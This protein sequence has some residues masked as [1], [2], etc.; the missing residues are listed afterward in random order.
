LRSHGLQL[1]WFPCKRPARKVA[2]A[3]SHAT[4][5]QRVSNVHL[6]CSAAHAGLTQLLRLIRNIDDTFT[7]A[8]RYPLLIFHDD[9]MTQS[10]M[11]ELQA[12]TSRPL[13]FALVH[14]Q[15]GYD[16]SPHCRHLSAGLSGAI[17]PTDWKLDLGL[18]CQVLSNRLSSNPPCVTRTSRSTTATCNAT[19]PHIPGASLAGDAGV[20]GVS[21][22]VGAVG[23]AGT[24]DRCRFFAIQ[25]FHQVRDLCTHTL[26]GGHTRTLT[27]T[28][29]PGAQ[30]HSSIA[31]DNPSY[32]FRKSA[33]SR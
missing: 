23:D 18:Q 9:E 30:T 21:V 27:P 12:T 3:V 4:G 22:E 5:G 25:L 16:A 13:E 6:L 32:L 15:G 28:R 17:F 8:P 29:P 7:H 14:F 20:G 24:R 1:S 33:T 10:T 31:K 11:S 26:A 2:T 19:R